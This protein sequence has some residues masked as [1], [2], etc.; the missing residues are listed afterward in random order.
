DRLELIK[1]SQVLEMFEKRVHDLQQGLAKFEQVKQFKL[2]PKAFS[3]DEG[4]LTPNQKLRRKVIN[5]RYQHEIEDMY[6]DKSKE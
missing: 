4:E 2:L 5:D 3:M 1:H 6:R